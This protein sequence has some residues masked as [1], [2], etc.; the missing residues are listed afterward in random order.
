MDRIV[1]I[2]NINPIRHHIRYNYQKYIVPLIT[3][4]NSDPNHVPLVFNFM[5]SIYKRIT[6][7]VDLKSTTTGNII[8]FNLINNVDIF[9]RKVHYSSNSIVKMFRR[10]DDNDVFI[11]YIDREIIHIVKK[12]Y[13]FTHKELLPVMLDMYKDAILRCLSDT[14]DEDDLSKIHMRANFI[15]INTFM[16]NNLINRIHI[17]HNESYHTDFIIGKDPLYLYMILKFLVTTAKEQHPNEAVDPKDLVRYLIG[18]NVNP[19]YAFNDVVMDVTLDDW[20]YGNYAI[21]IGSNNVEEFSKNLSDHTIDRCFAMNLLYMDKMPQYSYVVE[22]VSSMPT[23]I[24][25]YNMWHINLIDESLI[26]CTQKEISMA[27]DVKDC[28]DMVTMR[29]STYTS[30]M[31]APYNYTNNSDSQF[32]CNVY[33]GHNRVMAKVCFTYI[34]DEDERIR[35]TYSKYGGYYTPHMIQVQCNVMN[36][37]EFL[38]ILSLAHFSLDDHNIVDNMAYKIIDE[39]VNNMTVTEHM[40]Y[41]Y[42]PNTMYT[43][44]GGRY[45]S[46][47]D[48]NAT[49]SKTQESNYL[50]S[51]PKYIRTLKTAI[52]RRI[53]TMICLIIEKLRD[54]DVSYI[55]EVVRNRIDSDDFH[56]LSFR[57][58]VI[59]FDYFGRTNTFHSGS[60]YISELF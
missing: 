7:V 3:K 18:I 43:S 55:P 11:S 47:K 23:I 49:L 19:S 37:D 38:M 60:M 44:D 13:S 42:I 1:L 12:I 31:T 27:P 53:R 20:Y 5:D 52:S 16:H 58:K 59:E 15:S 22:N 26:G 30:M 24:L 48:S 28:N 14:Y 50:I 29:L 25:K 9:F 41:S 51:D 46:M 6:D 4:Y 17:E 39:L 10:I 21:R 34:V 33:P 57:D 45:T 54:N 36:N 2:H 8:H 35:F 32:H 40:I 56:G